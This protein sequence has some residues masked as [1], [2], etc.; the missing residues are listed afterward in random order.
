MV[1]VIVD[2]RKAALAVG[3]DHVAIALK[4]STHP[5]EVG[6]R[7]L[8]GHVVHTQLHRHRCVGFQ[9]ILL[10]LLQESLHR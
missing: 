1:A 3:R 10:R 9:R 5:L 4:T 6:Q 7:V 2:D 8:H